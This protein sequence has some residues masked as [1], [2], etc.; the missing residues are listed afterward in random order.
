MLTNILIDRYQSILI[1]IFKAYRNILIKNNHYDK[2]LK[3]IKHEIKLIISAFSTLIS[4][5]KN[6]FK[7]IFEYDS[8]S[9]LYMIDKE[10]FK[11]IKTIFESVSVLVNKQ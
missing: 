3:I 10:L 1:D 7:S 4:K 11:Y 9:I 6:T 5:G 2:Y 8:E